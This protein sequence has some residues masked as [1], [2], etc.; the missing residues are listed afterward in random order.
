M[1]R[2]TDPSACFA[3]LYQ[4]HAEA[5]FRLAVRATK[6]SAHAHDLV[7]EV[8]LKCWA[9][10]DHWP[11]INDL[12][13]WLYRVSANQLIDF[14]RKTAVDR[15]CRQQLWQQVQT[16][17]PT[18]AAIAF[19]AKEQARLL[20]AAIDLLPAQRRTIFLLNREEGMSYQEIADEMNL[21]RHTVKNQLSAAL[22]N[23]RR[24]FS[25]L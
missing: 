2:Q 14:I 22:Q 6:S 25:R 9:K 21:S 3:E 12:E 4:Q 1:L 16:S 11:E 8:F 17:T 13:A 5:L 18:D 19:D 20:R 24:F 23:L 7:Q 10:R 15:R